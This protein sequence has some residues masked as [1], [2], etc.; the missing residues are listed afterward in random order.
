MATDVTNMPGGA[1]PFRIMRNTWG[2][3]LAMGIILIILGTVAIVVPAA[4]SVTIT[5]FLGIILFIAAAAQLFHAIAAHR[6]GGFFLHLAGAVIYGIFAIALMGDPNRGVR[7]LTLLLA[8]YFLVSGFLRVLLALTAYRSPGWGWVLTSGVVNLI[9]GIL[10]WGQ[11][12]G[13]TDWVIGL[14]VGIDLLFSGWSMVMLAVAARS[15][16]ADSP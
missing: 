4:V 8:M 1:V 11:W 6:W 16:P 14:L 3:F 9:L 2:M 10:I 5:V 12:P 13:N 7:A 15:L